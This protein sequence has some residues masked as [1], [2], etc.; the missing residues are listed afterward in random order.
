MP[1]AAL[2]PVCFLTQRLFEV[3]PTSQDMGVVADH[4]QRYPAHRVFFKKRALI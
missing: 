3:E 4:C 2:R 1:F